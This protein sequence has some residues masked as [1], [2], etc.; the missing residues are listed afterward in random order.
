MLNIK[1]P[2][3]NRKEKIS[4]IVEFSTIFKKLRDKEKD[5]LKELLVYQDALNYN[6]LMDYNVRVKVREGLNISEHNFNNIISS[7]RKRGVIINNEIIKYY[8]D[9]V[10]QD[11]INITFNAR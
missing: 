7:L 4:F 11:G 1:L 9:L 2:I 8:L 10:N 3:E 5:V 6:V